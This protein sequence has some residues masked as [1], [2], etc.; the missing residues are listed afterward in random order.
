MQTKHVFTRVHV[1]EGTACARHMHQLHKQCASLSILKTNRRDVQQIIDGCLT[2]FKSDLEFP[3]FLSPSAR[4]EISALS[5][6]Q[7][8]DNRE[9]CR[10]PQTR[11]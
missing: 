11:H 3:G 1:S 2:I 10:A 6:L 9:P 4:P 8:S 7:N 5:N